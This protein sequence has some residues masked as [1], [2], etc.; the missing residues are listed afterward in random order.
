MI[1][2]ADA[3]LTAKARKLLIMDR[4]SKAHAMGSHRLHFGAA[5]GHRRTVFRELDGA[6]EAAHHPLIRAL[7]VP[8]GVRPMSQPARE[9]LHPRHV[10]Q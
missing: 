2:L 8:D 6:R 1:I 3:G 9:S 4:P 10:R 7:R 5:P